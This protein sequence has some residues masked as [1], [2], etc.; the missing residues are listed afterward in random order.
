MIDLLARRLCVRDDGTGKS[1]EEDATFADFEAED[2]IVLL[3]DPGMGKTTFFREASHGSYSTVRRF[4][5]MPQGITARTLFLD[6]LDEYRAIT[7]EIG[8]A[9]V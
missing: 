2:A 9:H 8:R 5:I 1:R 6:A 7:G 4:L 3:G